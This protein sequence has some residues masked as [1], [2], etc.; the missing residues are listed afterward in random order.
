MNVRL[1][2]QR[3]LKPVE[4]L[5]FTQ[6]SFSQHILHKINGLTCYLGNNTEVINVYYEQA[7]I[8]GGIA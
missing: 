7:T 1:Y 4:Y 6:K 2:T 8:F 3:Q 5:D